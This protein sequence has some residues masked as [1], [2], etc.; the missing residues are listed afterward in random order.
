M[1][2]FVLAHLWKDSYVCTGHEHNEVNHGSQ[3][4]SQCSRVCRIGSRICRTA[5]RL[6]SSLPRCFFVFGVVMAALRRDDFHL[7]IRRRACRIYPCCTSL[8]T[9]I[10]SCNVPPHCYGNEHR[11]GGIYRYRPRRCYV[12]AALVVSSNF[13]YKLCVCVSICMDGDGTWI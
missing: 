12:H 5:S 11:H 7:Q 4:T 3:K 6:S 2:L 9:A 8:W 1:S 13:H 10:S